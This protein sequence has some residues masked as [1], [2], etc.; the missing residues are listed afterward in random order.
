MTDWQGDLPYPVKS[1]LEDMGWQRTQY[2]RFSSEPMEISGKALGYVAKQTKRT[3]Q[4]VLE[5]IEHF[6]DNPSPRG[7]IADLGA[8]LQESVDIPT[9]M[10]ELESKNVL[11]RFLELDY[12][13]ALEIAGYNE[14][15]QKAREHLQIVESGVDYIEK[16][17]IK[18]SVKFEDVCRNIWAVWI[19]KHQRSSVGWTS[20]QSVWLDP[21][22]VRLANTDL[23]IAR[24]DLRG[25]SQS[26]VT[27]FFFLC[28]LDS[29]FPER[30]F[31]REKF[32]TAYTQ[33]RKA[34][35]ETVLNDIDKSKM[36][37][38]QAEEEVDRI[39]AD[40]PPAL[41]LPKYTFEILDHLVRIDGVDRIRIKSKYRMEDIEVVKF[42]GR[43]IKFPFGFS[44]SQDT[45]NFLLSSSDETIGIAEWIGGD[46]PDDFMLYLDNRGITQ[47]AFDEREGRFDE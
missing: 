30:G 37:R 6:K 39:V 3:E 13:I 26:Q 29:Y 15:H 17:D 9:F 4:E 7:V 5:S 2:D 27:R 24:L 38:E 35:L 21:T 46:V 31:L 14:I 44:Y 22:M 23:M 11:I 1:F 40:K 28:R 47:H 34:L 20:Q 18:S 41:Q 36:T 10:F 45:G 19:D 43:L 8:I 32:L 25:N 16:S 33:G 12:E 42:L